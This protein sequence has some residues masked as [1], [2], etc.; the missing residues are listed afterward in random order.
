MKTLDRQQGKLNNIIKPNKVIEVI[1]KWKQNNSNLVYIINQHSKSSMKKR[2][3]SKSDLIKSIEQFDKFYVNENRI[4]V[5]KQIWEH[6]IRTIYSFNMYT[7]KVFIIS[8]MHINK[9]K[10]ATNRFDSYV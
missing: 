6:V 1:N 7:N 10:F 3:I 4:I 9:K 8:T 2:R 5:E